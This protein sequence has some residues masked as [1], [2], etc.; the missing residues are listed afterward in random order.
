MKTNQKV[1][2]CK[3]NFSVVEYSPTLFK[4]YLND[5]FE[6]ESE[7]SYRNT[8]THKLQTI[9]YLIRGGYKILYFF[10]NSKP[11][12]YVAFAKG[13]DDIFQ[14][15][16]N[17]DLYIV[18]YYTFQKYRGM[19]YAS[20]LSKFLIDNYQYTNIYKCIDCHNLPSIRVSEKNGF[21]FIGYGRKTK[22]IHRVVFDK[23]KDLNLY[24][25][26]K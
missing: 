12:C 3:D 1:L 5:G 13:G 14:E 7:L 19:G 9:K 20:Y 16:N 17:K 10:I 4:H 24:R 15:S 21:K 25:Y 23:N 8:I 26:E 11:V 18:V 22:G 2:F 6:S